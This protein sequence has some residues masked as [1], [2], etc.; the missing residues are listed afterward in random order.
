MVIVIAVVVVLVGAGGVW[1]WLG[2]GSGGGLAAEA[3]T[4]ATLRLYEQIP[5]GW[6]PE[7][8]HAPEMSVGSWTDGRW[9]TD[10]H[11]V[12]ELPD[13]I[14]AY[15][16]ADW[17]VAWRLPVEGSGACLSSREQSPEGYVAVLRGD[18][19]GGGAD[20]KGC[21]QLTLVD[22]TSGKEV[23]TKE[24]Q[25][26]LGNSLPTSEDLPVIFGDA[27][28]VPSSGGAHKLSLADGA[29]T[30]QDRD[31]C[32]INALWRVGDML[33]TRQCS[34][35]VAFDENLEKQW[36]WEFPEGDARLVMVVSLDPLIVVMKD[37][38]TEEVWRVKPGT[39]EEG[40]PGEHTVVATADD[41]EYRSP[42]GLEAQGSGLTECSR[43]VA[44]DGV[45]YLQ[46]DLGRRNEG[47][48]AVNIDTGEEVWRTSAGSEQALIPLNLADDGRLIAYRPQVDSADRDEVDDWRGLVVAVDPKTGNL[49]PLAALPADDEELP[50]GVRGVFE[51]TDVKALEWH[52][53]HLVFADDTVVVTQ[54]GRGGGS[55][56]PSTIV[57]G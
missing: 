54:P 5:E 19:F 16:R 10:K 21:H 23:W 22:I 57:F 36:V 50:S 35:L 12:R 48:A 47:L 49:A 32:R 53:G 38:T 15:S 52:D 46:T 30:L 4:Q 26:G 51:N 40:S 11:L 9:W 14:V 41:G 6:E 18:G 55:G 29:E 25:P 8:E 13:E 34:A 7:R 42:C 45:V 17:S 33:L 43:V 27:V 31:S 2:G 24:L 44:G 28:R 1:L 56:S 3:P 39:G 20:E 37:G